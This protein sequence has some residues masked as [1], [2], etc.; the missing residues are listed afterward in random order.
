HLHVELQ[1]GAAV[2]PPADSPDGAASGLEPA[3]D[4]P[5]LHGAA[6]QGVRAG[7]VAVA[8]AGAA[9]GGAT[10]PLRHSEEIC[11]RATET[12]SGSTTETQRHRARIHE[13]TTVRCA[14]AA[15]AWN[16]NR[17]ARVSRR[18]LSDRAR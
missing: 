9:A 18:H 15:Y 2:R 12:Q 1:R 4:E 11:H 10:D 8:V 3:R 14:Y 5:E 7:T 16:S 13:A 6:V 17:R